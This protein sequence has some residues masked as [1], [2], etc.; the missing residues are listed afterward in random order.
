MSALVPLVFLPL[1]FYTKARK[2]AIIIYVH[3]LLNLL[4]MADGDGVQTVLSALLL[5]EETRGIFLHMAYVRRAF[6]D[7]LRRVPNAAYFGLC[8]LLRRVPIAINDTNSSHCY[9]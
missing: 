4:C 7:L 6:A 1:Y 9:E 8:R 2:I 5:A 3:T